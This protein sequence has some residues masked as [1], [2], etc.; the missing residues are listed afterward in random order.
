MAKNTKDITKTI[1]APLA[2]TFGNLTDF[3]SSCYYRGFEDG[4]LDGKREG[5]EEGKREGQ[6]HALRRRRELAEAWNDH[7]QPLV[8]GIKNAIDDEP[9]QTGMHGE[10]L[11]E[12]GQQPVRATRKPY[13]EK[14][15]RGHERVRKLL[16]TSSYTAAPTL[17]GLLGYSR[18]TVRTYMRDLM[19]HGV[20]I[21]TKPLKGGYRGRSGY[22]V[23]YRLAKTG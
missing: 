2:T 22:R 11:H 15:N 5:F 1:P 16:D 3:A 19:A 21:E 4:F 18:A 14:L 8:T 20:E 9:G 7:G 13:R 6:T 23:G 12:S 10:P 17:A